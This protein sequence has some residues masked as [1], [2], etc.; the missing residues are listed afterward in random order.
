MRVLILAPF[1]DGPLGELCEEAEVVCESWL[2]TGQ[3]QDPAELGARLH[4][5][6][7]DAVVV[8]G[9]FLFAETFDAAPALRFAGICR[10]STN[11]VDVAAAT[12]RGVVVV[13]TPGRNA[14]AVAEHAL[15]LMLA[16]ARRIPAA[17]AYVR[18]RR[19]ESPSEPY[20]SMRGAEL[21]GKVLGI[22][23]L[24]AIGRRVAALGNA[25]GMHV[26]ACDPV[27]GRPE[28]EA[29]GAVWSDL[30][31]LLESADIVSLHAPPPRDGQPLLTAARLARMRKGAVLINTASPEL[32]DQGALADALRTGRLGG[33][34]VDIFPTHPVEPSYPLLELGNVVLTP[35]IGG[36]TD[37]TVERHSAAMAVDLIRFKNGERPLNLVNPEV[38]GHRRG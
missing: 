28:A 15:A 16:V 3:L 4:R 27:V 37:G 31:F 9:D 11:Q 23:G 14:N 13:N 30:D 38:W 1:A 24:G 7:F 17:D 2:D 34:G 29:A 10:A 8:E 21:S 35:H 25:L 20:R 22:V 26:I 12:E 6:G 36:A 32:V 19:W 18:S 33:A 5:E